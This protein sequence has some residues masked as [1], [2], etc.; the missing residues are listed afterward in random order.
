MTAAYD[1]VLGFR[2][3]MW[4]VASL[5]QGDGMIVYPQLYLKAAGESIV[6]A[7]VLSW[8][9]TAIYHPDTIAANKLKNVVG[10]NNPCVGWDFPPAVYVALP[11]TVMCSYFSWRYA[12]LDGILTGIVWSGNGRPR[13]TAVL[14]VVTD[15]A[16]GISTTL[17][18]LLFILGPTDE[19]WPV[20][21][22]IFVQWIFFRYFVV[23]SNILEASWDGIPVAPYIKVFAW[24]YGIISC[25]LP[26]IY[27]YAGLVY[28]YEGRTGLDPPIPWWFT[29]SVDYGWFVCV[30]ITPFCLPPTK[31]LHVAYSVHDGGATDRFI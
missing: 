25:S 12:N 21:T 8:I 1:A 13:W 18:P 4:A 6:L 11:L 26:L 7:L 22:A 28:I 2:S 19:N 14:C 23:L 5:E 17:L 30:C 20:H 29:W 9:L 10:Y 27:L 31:V 16:Y 3:A 24:V 15:Y